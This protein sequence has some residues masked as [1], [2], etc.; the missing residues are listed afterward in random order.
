M[1][2]AAPR[3]GRPSPLGAS[4]ATSRAGPGSRLIGAVRRAPTPVRLRALLHAVWVL[5]VVL[6]LVGAG[7]LASARAALQKI[8]K[9]SAPSILAAQ[10]VSAGLA[11]LDALAGN[12]LLG[13]RARRQ[14]AI[15]AFD[16]RRAQVT[17]ALVTAARSV[18]SGDAALVPV[19]T[20]LDGLGRYLE[21]VAE[22]RYRKDLA[23]HAGAV[24][25]YEAASDLLHLRLLPAADTLDAESRHQLESEY[26]RQA[27]R[28]GL[29][30]VI[31]GLVGGLL[32]AVLG[33]G[34]LFLYRRTRRILNVPLLGATVVA[35]A[36]TLYLAGSIAAARADL[37]RAKVDA[38]EPIHALSRARAL[39]HDARGD[40]T[41]Y[42]LVPD[43]APLFER[44]YR[45]KIARLDGR[46]HLDPGATAS[47]P[48][49]GGLF[50]DARR[51]VTF[52]GAREAVA[53][54]LLA[55]A[56]FDRLDE[57]LRALERAGK[58]DRAVDL[59]VGAVSDQAPAVFDR[60]D[61]ALLAAVDIDQRELD[62]TVDEGLRALG[63][64]IAIGPIAS[65]LVALLAFLGVRPR[66]RE[67]AA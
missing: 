39:A 17:A 52:P 15:P 24:R 28:G 22:A 18:T 11:D 34:Q 54:M 51:H 3:A 40:Q 7:A 31:A 62:R 20:I 41:R 63:A 8:G 33:A 32:V 58:H 21:L 9:D 49:D 37:R 47:P 27:D 50:A 13:D 12:D 26:H 42:L 56:A 10:A 57:Q 5:A 45:D 2:A 30:A 61:R 14:D 44:E 53:S 59:C 65:L 4:G 19:D 38:F 55:F 67:Y 6:S 25:T 46:P 29:H 43:R 60:F 66:L 1:S 16:K 23:D 64:A 36:S 35:A 48:G